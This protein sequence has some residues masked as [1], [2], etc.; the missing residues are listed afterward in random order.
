M[1]ID[2]LV[3]EIGSTTTVVNA[4]NN[5]TTNPSFIGQG[6]AKTTINDVTIGLNEAIL[7]LQK[8][9]ETSSIDANEIFAS[10]SSA[11][12]LK[13]TVHGLVYDM[14]VKAAKEAALGAGANIKMITS[15]KL[16][17]FDLNKLKQIEPNIIMLSGG[18]NYGEVS[19]ALYNAN[20]IASLQLNIPVIYAGNIAARDEIKEIFTLNN[21]EDYLYIC[22]NVYPMIDVLDV[23]EARTIIQEVFEKHITKA[24]GMEKVREIVN[25]T[26]IPTPGA[27]MEATILLNKHL[28]NIVTLDIGGATTDVHSVCEDSSDS[29]KIIF[30]PEPFIKRTVEGDLGVFVNKDN[31]VNLIGKQVIARKLN[32]NLGEL[33]E[34]LENYNAIPNENQIKLVELLS[35]EALNEAITRHA[36]KYTTIYGTSGKKKI[37]EGKNLT[38]VDYII[39]TGGPLTKLNGR[40]IISEMLSN[41][42]ELSLKPKPNTNIIIDT[43]YIMASLGVIAKKYPEAALKLL[44]QSLN[45]GE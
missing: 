36:G 30:Y 4:F 45:L 9:L 39:G 20:E 26:I 32:I 37:A 28:G 38:N 43:K 17:K 31:I 13:M 19:T 14:T 34:L 7:D 5:L 40:K 42:N 25:G 6:L 11:G 44:K 27:V 1:K 41:V 22:T 35:I 3:A 8:N 18:V 21:Q 23:N 10:S 33:N 15:G 29:K 16:T 12:G 2:C 24:K